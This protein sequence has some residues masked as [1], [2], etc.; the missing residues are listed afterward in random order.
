MPSSAAICFER[1][2]AIRS[3]ATLRSRLD[4]RFAR[5]STARRLARRVR[6]CSS[7]CNASRMRPM[8]TG[9]DAGFSRKSIAPPRRACT[10][11]GMDPW[12][13][14]TITGG[15]TGRE[16]KSS[17]SCRPSSP[18]SMT[19]RTIQPRCSGSN[20]AR[21]STQD[22]YP[23]VRRPWA[24]SSACRDPRRPGSSSTTY[25]VGSVDVM[26]SS[27]NDVRGPTCGWQGEAD[28][29]T[30]F[31]GFR[32]DP[33]AATVVV[34]DRPGDGQAHP[35]AVGLRGEEGLEHAVGQLCRDARAAVL[36]LHTDLTT[37]R[38]PR[39]HENPPRP[40]ASEH[41]GVDGVLEKIDHD[42]LDLD[43]TGLHPA[44]H[45]IAD[46]LQRDPV[47]ADGRSDEVRRVDDELA[48]VAGLRRALAVAQEPY[49]VNDDPSRPLGLG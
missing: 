40:V 48:K 32:I 31:L 9:G 46:D 27:S 18:S 3:S 26:C 11:M 17:S 14:R 4:R 15:C 16:C 44:R 49:D 34:H 37:R 28:A 23:A 36:N 25:T 42:L 10:D 22:A 24:A 43:T 6:S 33:Y 30:F 47:L 8:R 45:G 35:E 38:G 12:P 21:N 1:W 2:P 19:S 13:V 29:A 20:E 5:S 41:D 39:L 7:L